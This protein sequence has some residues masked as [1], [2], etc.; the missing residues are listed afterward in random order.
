[1]D[2]IE[3]CWDCVAKSERR[4]YHPYF[5]HYHLEFNEA[6]GKDDFRNTINRI[7]RRNHLAYELKPEGNVQRLIE[8]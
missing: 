4:D 6:V 1:M 5:G 7:F 2:M 8:C 3:F